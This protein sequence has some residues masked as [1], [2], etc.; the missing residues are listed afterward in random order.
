VK[1]IA[2]KISA[3][4]RKK[5][6]Y[7]KPAFRIF[8]YLMSRHDFMFFTYGE[9]VRAIR[10]GNPDID[11]IEDVISVR[12]TE[13]EALYKLFNLESEIRENVFDVI[14][15]WTFKSYDDFVRKKDSQERVEKYIK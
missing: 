6:E 1:R 9:K 3:R 13:I 11:T 14:D 8:K 12:T 2:Q 4:I 5:F 15:S 10:M 7:L